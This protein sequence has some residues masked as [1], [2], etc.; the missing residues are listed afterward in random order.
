MSDQES[1]VRTGQKITGGGFWVLGQDQDSVGGG[2]QDKDS[3]QG[4]LAEMNVWG[5]VLTKQEI[6]RFST[7]CRRR[8]NGSVKSWPQ[9]RT[10]LRG[11]AR[12][13]NEPNC[14]KRLE[15]PHFNFLGLLRKPC[16]VNLRYLSSTQIWSSTI[17]SSLL[18][19]KDKSSEIEAGQ[20]TVDVH[21]LRDTLIRS[22][23][24][25]KSIGDGDILPE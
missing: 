2:F 9:F 8:M 3:F 14:T 5:R 24:P 17:W 25:R 21:K 1:G 13:I 20:E 23:Q 16:D 15:Y 11:K 22:K 10:G 4:E 7:D 19:N 18:S 6:A 12:V